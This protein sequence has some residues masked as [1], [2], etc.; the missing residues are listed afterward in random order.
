MGRKLGRISG[1]MVACGKMVCDDDGDT[2]ERDDGG[3]GNK[4]TRL[5]IEVSGKAARLVHKLEWQ[6]AK[7]NWISVKAHQQ[8]IG[9]T[10]MCAENIEILCC[11]TPYSPTHTQTHTWASDN[12][13][14]S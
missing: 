9:S 6:P 10:D 3:G 4:H 11:E 13:G 14:E 12:F 1:R 2:S 5:R 7:V 8:P